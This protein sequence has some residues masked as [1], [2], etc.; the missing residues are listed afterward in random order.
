MDGHASHAKELLD[1][2]SRELKA[3]AMTANKN[4]K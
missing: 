1:Q 3:A 4:H 2:A